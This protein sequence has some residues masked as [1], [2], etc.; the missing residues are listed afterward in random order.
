MFELR[1]LNK[2]F[3]KI[4]ALTDLSLSIEPG[5]IRG[6]VGS[7][8]AGKT[9][10]MRIALG[11]LSADSGEVIWNGKPVSLQ[12]R[13]K[14]G[15]M[16]EERG[17]YPRMR[18]GD[19]LVYFGQLHGLSLDEAT[20]RMLS[21]TEQINL[22][23]RRK[24]TVDKLSLGNQ[25]RVQLATALLHNPKV[26][27]LDE[28]FSGLDPIAVETMSKVLKERKE[29][30]VATLFSSHQLDLVERLCDNVTIISQG[31]VVAD[32]TISQLRDSKSPIYLLR[33]ESR[34]HLDAMK[35]A[36][37]GVPGVEHVEV[38]TDLEGNFLIVTLTR[39]IEGPRKQVLESALAVGPVAEFVRERRP[40]SEIYSGVVV[41]SNNPEEDNTNTSKES[42]SIIK[43]L[44][45][46]GRK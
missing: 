30:G 44:F 18:V 2:S 25:Q 13:T 1:N 7:N 43:R 23:S 22:Q 20:K 3:G 28:P 31:M 42:G 32:G 33:P 10:A 37:S 15:Y 29:Q 9:T 11:V 19:Q 17:L 36:L 26:I 41:S 39:P 12:D 24:D 16:P 8:G 21:I 6:F 14:I 4:K 40:L 35:F 27:V 46:F 34:A 38:G 45:S 5:A